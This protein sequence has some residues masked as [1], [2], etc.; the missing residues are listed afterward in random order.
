MTLHQRRRAFEDAAPVPP[1]SPPPAVAAA[2]LVSALWRRKWTVAGVALATLL[3]AAAMLSRLEPRYA[4]MAEVLL[5]SRRPQVVDLAEVMPALPLDAQAV[6]SEIRLIQSQQLLERVARKLR[7][8]EDPELGP[9]PAVEPGA[10]AQLKAALA[11]LAGWSAP[12]RFPDPEREA[13]RALLETIA[14]MRKRLSVSQQDLSRVIAIRFESADPDKAALIANAIAD[15]YIV[16]QLEAKFDATRR[17]SQWLSRRLDELAARL[18]EA[19]AAVAAARARR[20]ELLAGKA[21]DTRARIEDMAR[22]LESLPEGS[23]RR[24]ALHATLEDLRARAEAQSR[25][26]AELRR[27]EREAAA[28][29]DL[30]DS[31]L[32]RLKETNAQ[33]GLQQPDARLIGAAAPPLR[34]A[35][36]NA[37]L[38]LGFALMGGLAAGGALALLRE[39]LGGVWHSLEAA[40]AET[41]L[42]VLAALPRAP[43]W[44][45][46]PVEHVRKRP[47]SEL[48]EAVRELR[49]ALAPPGSGPRVI[50]V[51]S[52]GPAEG[53]ST[54]SALLAE[55]CARMGR[56]AA[57]VDCDLRRPAQARRYGLSAEEDL[58]AVLEGET[59]LE[60]ALREDRRTGVSIL[61]SQEAPATRADALAGPAFEALMRELRGRF[62]VVVLDTP[63]L[64]AVSDA[65]VIAAFADA[66]V[67]VARWGETTRADARA[68]LR[69]LLDAGVE[70]AGLALTGASRREADNMDGGGRYGRFSEY[71]AQ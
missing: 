41:G 49:A 27:L 48:G 10:L 45:E 5:E 66:A 33:T 2:E 61:P 44:R 18:A 42:P 30:H 31:F 50:A 52:A 1:S 14:A 56:S 16:D 40:E 51:V 8:H 55:S 65:R 28:I 68:A 71:F 62:D 60:A 22:M 53:K 24:A 13:R 34:P 57:L 4:A 58:L 23:P 29:R 11:D 70:T 39:S 19:D 36:P 15:Q 9:A 12:V 32:A 6:Q 63:P 3:F 20:A 38:I 59:P 46:D 47:G 21:E 64:L 25:A 17:A 37:P 35:F 43:G 54:L 69:I 67:F 7:L 26:D